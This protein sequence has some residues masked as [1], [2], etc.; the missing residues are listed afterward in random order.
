MQVKPKIMTT[1]NY[2]ILVQL[3]EKVLNKSL[4]MVFYSGMLKVEDTYVLE[5]DIPN[6]FKPYTTFNYKISL[7][8]EPFVDFRSEDEL[9][10]RLAAQLKVVVLAGIELTFSLDFYVKCNIKFDMANSKLYFEL[11]DAQVV[12]I[13]IQHEYYVGKEFL[14]KLNFIIDEIIKKYFKDE[15]QEIAIPIAID[16]LPLPMMPAGD[17]YKLPVSKVDIKILNKEVLVV[18]VSLF[19]ATGS[20]SGMSNLTQ[21]KD[22]YI[23]IKEQ[24]IK[25]TLEFWWQNTTF[26]KN[27]QFNENVE[28]GFAT[29]LASGVDKVTR[30]I[31][32]GFVQTET[33]Y[34]DMMLLY[35]GEV[36]IEKMPDIDLKAGNTVSIGNLEF[37]ADLYADLV[38]DVLK[39]VDFDTSSFIPDH[40]TPWKDDIDIK[41]VDKHKTL[42]KLKNTFTL[43]INNAEGEL[44]ITE[45]N[46][47]AVKITDADFRI[48]FSKKGTTFSDNTWEKLM[49]FIKE[50]VLE[51]I[52]E[53]IISPSL[54]LATQNVFGFTLSL[55]NTALT[56]SDSEIVLSTDVDINEL[57]TNTVAVP[58]YIGDEET[59]KVHAITCADIADID[60]DHRIG[61]YVMYEAL[62]DGYKACNKCLKS[63]NLK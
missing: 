45:E 31:T 57:K 48:E 24:A 29:P 55:Q 53:I 63:Y 20:L 21:G 12:S 1:G 27:Q 6:S 33:D 60:T 13:G 10:I 23:A 62:A 50:K 59:K 38:A 9:F 56:I 42:V 30:A 49:N 25:Q 15:V 4:A 51:R 26:T 36:K 16:G 7:A 52:P 35:G 14:A 2:D 28:I 43:Q 8:N 3:H 17:Q 61:Y 34:E 44:R 39:D 58:N 47:L 54:I 41:K 46:N 40:I 5:K 11:L 22:C 19:S 32:L 37:V 18:G